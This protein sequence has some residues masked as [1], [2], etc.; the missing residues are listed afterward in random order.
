L[1]FQKQLETELSD[2]YRQ[3][4][5]DAKREMANVNVKCGKSDDRKYL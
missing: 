2:I 1:G 4:K 3:L 5:S